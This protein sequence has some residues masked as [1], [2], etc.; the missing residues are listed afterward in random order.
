MDFQ[1]SEA[2]MRNLV[3]LSRRSSQTWRVETE[4]DCEDPMQ[5]RLMMVCTKVAWAG[6][7]AT[8]EAS[9]IGEE[10]A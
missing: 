8:W 5:S 6:S 9:R 3:S 7:R 4:S 2:K 1:V 10:I